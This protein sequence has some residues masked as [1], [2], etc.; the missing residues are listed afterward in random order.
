MLI[1]SNKSIGTNHFIAQRL[2]AVIN[3]IIGIPAFIIFLNFYDKGYPII[4]D[5]LSKEHIWIPMVIY[6]VSISYHMKIGMGHMLD[7]YFDNIRLKGFL[8]VLN[9]L[10]V[11]L[12]ALFSSIS[13]IILGMF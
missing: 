4:R 9:R 10:Y 12:V 5:L 7:D 1:L 11:Y 8:S 2:T 6:I 3:L 13:L